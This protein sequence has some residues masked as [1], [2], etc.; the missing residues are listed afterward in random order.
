MSLASRSLQVWA[1]YVLVLGLGLLLIPNMVFSLFGIGD[2]LGG[3]WT[4][5]ALQSKASQQAV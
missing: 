2:F 1:G 5:A 3:L 4:F